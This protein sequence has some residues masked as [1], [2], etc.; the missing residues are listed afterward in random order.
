M[1]EKLQSFFV[2]GISVGIS[3]MGPKSFLLLIHE[4]LWI[5]YEI[6]PIPKQFEI[7]GEAKAFFIKVLWWTISMKHDLIFTMV[8]ASWAAVKHSRIH[9]TFYNY[10]AMISFKWVN[11][12]TKKLLQVWQSCTEFTKM[13]CLNHIMNLDY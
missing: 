11:S 13:L 3:G 9:S 7:A 10:F 4:R 12:W 2:K 5:R 6:S 1:L 8:W